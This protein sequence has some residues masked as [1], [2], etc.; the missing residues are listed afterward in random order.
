MRELPMT[1]TDPIRLLLSDVDGTLVTSAKELTG[2]S[3][4]AVGRLRG[5]AGGEPSHRP[6]VRQIRLL[7]PGQY[8]LLFSGHGRSSGLPRKTGA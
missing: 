7:G 3:V 6:A 1:T 5:D 2:A 4:A 8:R